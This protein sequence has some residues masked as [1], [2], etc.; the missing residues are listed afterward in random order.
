MAGTPTS[1]S[2]ARL[3]SNINSADI[4][5]NVSPV[6]LMLQDDRKNL[7]TYLSGL[8]TRGV[9]NSRFDWFSDEILPNRGTVGTGFASGTSAATA[10]IDL[11]GQATTV[12]LKA[13]DVI[14]LP[15]NGEILRVT[16]TPATMATVP[17]ARNRT[18][19]ATGAITVGSLWIKIGDARAG[20]SRLFDTS[21]NLQALTVNNTSAY[22]Y[23]QTF[24]E[25]FGMSRRESKTKLYSGKDEATQKAKSLMQH[26][27][28]IEQAFWYGQRLDEGNERTLTGGVFS[29]LLSGNSSI[30]P[31][32]TEE[33]F[34]NFVRRITRYG[35]RR[36][37]VLFCS[38]FVAT[39]ISGWARANQRVDSKGTTI[40]YGVH[41]DAYRTGA[42]TDIEIITADAL[43]GLP[44]STTNGVYDGYA[45]LMEMNEKKKVVFGGD[46]MKYAEGVEFKDMD[47]KVNAYL[48][49]VGYQPGDPRK[50]GHMTGITG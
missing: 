30:V 29:F 34:D 25:P 1:V 2:G 24:R 12:Y 20:L 4:V 41:V 47:G 13:D 48:S 17:V 36:K 15:E 18:G 37:R 44:G 3:V 7:M 11:S 10:N 49:D 46:D 38:R 21:G 40:K 35:N 45:V 27:E 39:R 23:T 32:L 5:K 8:G 6:V 14:H 26:C 42:G 31:T 50:D 43:E 9:D 19:L 33:E 16:A 22:N 28:N